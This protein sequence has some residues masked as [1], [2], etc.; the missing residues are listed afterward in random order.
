MKNS[1]VAHPYNYVAIGILMIPIA[2]FCFLIYT[3]SFNMISRDEYRIAGTFI[4]QFHQAATFQEYFSA[5]YIQE[6]ESR[7]IFVRILYLLT[8]LIEGTYDF[9]TVCLFGNLELLTY[10]LILGLAFR[11]TGKSLLYF[12]PV[13]F[14]LLNLSPYF[15]FFFSYETYFYIASFFLPVTIFYTATMGKSKI[16]P[17]LLALLCIG[18]GS[19]TS[20]VTL[21]LISLRILEKKYLSAFFFAVILVISILVIPKDGAGKD[22]GIISEILLNARDLALL[23]F[24]LIGNFI[25]VFSKNGTIIIGVGVLVSVSAFISIITTF[26]WKNN[27][28]RFLTISYLFFLVMLFFN[29][30]RR[31]RQ[32]YEGYLKEIV[33]GHK[34]I[35]S[36]AFLVI[37]Y[38]ICVEFFSAKKYLRRIHLAMMT[39]VAVALYLTANFNNISNVNLLQKR[40]HTDIANWELTN[41]HPN[42]IYGIYPYM[43]KNKLFTHGESFDQ[44][45]MNV[46]KQKL[47]DTTNLNR[48]YPFEVQLSKSNTKNTYGIQVTDFSIECP[49]YP[50]PKSLD[51]TNGFYI[52]LVSKKR[53]VMLP[54]MLNKLSVRKLLKTGNPYNNGLFCQSSNFEVASDN[55]KIAICTVQNNQLVDFFFIDKQLAI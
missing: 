42:D 2:I 50:Y 6:N 29:C 5:F 40:L 15:T 25:S 55:Y 53:T 39:L 11:S 8:Y 36:V 43:T 10:I 48:H 24:A 35:F 21:L 49:S 26:N 13:P 31:W 9:R 27:Y 32:D 16:T 34:I 30:V 47:K 54:A 37:S 4:K 23:V 7:P 20:V 18:V 38:L 51:K 52:L 19:V 1:T 46:I 12:I 33:N 14:I 3:N 41:S 28:H 45:L 22:A 17:Y 44:P